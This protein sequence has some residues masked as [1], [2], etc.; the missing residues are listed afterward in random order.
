MFELSKESQ[1]KI[2]EWVAKFPADKSRSAVIMALRIVQDEYGWLSDDALK[3]VGA[4]LN[5]PEVEVFE[6]VSFYSM[7][8]RKPVGN[9]KIS[10]CNSLSCYLCKGQNLLD[11]LDK[12]YGVKP[13]E[14]TKNGLFTVDVAEC[15]AACG[16]APAVLVGDDEYYENMTIDKLDELINSFSDKD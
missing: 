1:V 7:Y 4:Y 14:T 2:D 13:G 15:L 9:Y 3:A 10:I 16:G 12:K 8:R 5:I 11:H 6:V